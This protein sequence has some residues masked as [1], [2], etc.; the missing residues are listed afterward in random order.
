MN[1]SITIK[2]KPGIADGHKLKIKEKGG[3]GVNGGPR[4]DLVLVVHVS[5]PPVFE[6]RG[7]DLYFDHPISVLDALTGGSISTTVIN[8]PIN[9]AVPPGTDSGKTFRL[10]GLGMPKYSGEGHG[11]CYLKVNIVVPKNLTKNEMEL[12]RTLDCLRK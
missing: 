1:A 8:R 12:L 9:I 7:D 3:P 5:E 4:G 6:R 10:K 11:D 2:L